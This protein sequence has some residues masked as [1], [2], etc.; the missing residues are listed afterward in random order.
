MTSDRTARR[1][2]R[3]LAMVPWVVAHPGTSVT[4]VCQ[5]FGYTRADLA[6]D[7]DLIF[8]CGMPGYGPGDLMVAY[9]D[10]DE[11]VVDMADYFAR[12]IR[13]TPVEALVLLAGGMVLLS[14]GVAPPALASAVAKLQKVLLPGGDALAIEAPAE[15]ELVGTL[16]RAAAAGEVIDLVY[17]SIARGETTRRLVEPHSLFSTMGNWYL[18]GF[19]RLASAER[20]FRVDRIR[21]ATTTEEHFTPPA[22]LPP[23]E[24][25]YTPGVDDVQ[26]VIRLSPAAAWVADYYPVELLSSDDKGQVVRFSAR[27]PAVAGRLLVRLGRDAVLLEGDEVAAAAERLRQRMLGR[28]RRSHQK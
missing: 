13:L 23:A 3:I 22:Q 16:G 8:V 10:G 4:E 14:S 5:R 2:S 28:Y 9:I 6:R 15:P 24:V 27:D 21:Q 7:L 18:A 19:C 11:V 26:A 12:P 1:L 25:R 17:T 20:V